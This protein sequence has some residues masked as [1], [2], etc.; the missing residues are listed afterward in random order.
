MIEILIVQVIA[1]VGLVVL[2]RWLFTRH[3]TTSIQ[4]LEQLYRDNLKRE[5]ELKQRLQLVEKECQQKVQDAEHQAKT[6]MAAGRLEADKARAEL[7]Q[8]ARLESERLIQEAHERR[9]EI[10]RELEQGVDRKAVQLASDAVRFVLTTQVEEGLH[11][12]LVDQLL[13]EMTGLEQIRL[14]ASASKAEVATAMPLKPEQKTRL[15]HILAEKAGRPVEV[16]ESLDDTVIAGMTVRLDNLI[17]DG[18]L[19][20]KLRDAVTYV[21]KSDTSA[22][23]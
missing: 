14:D 8:E 7:L 21:R 5:H 1:F 12:Q 2:L 20:N 10:R 17:L 6:L 4:R 9:D 18:S 19:R 22:G 23:G 16:A 3:V 13:Q 15:Q 11:G